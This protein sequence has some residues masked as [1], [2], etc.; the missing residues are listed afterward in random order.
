MKFPA[1]VALLASTALGMPAALE[2]RTWTGDGL[3]V[4]NVGYQGDGLY[5]ATFDKRGVAEVKFT[6]ARDLNLTARGALDDSAVELLARDQLER[7]NGVTC[8]GKSGDT[9]VMD[10]ANRQ[11]ASNADAHGVYL[12]NSWG[13]VSSQAFLVFPRSAM[14]RRRL[15]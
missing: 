7:R 5:L 4:R 15:T 12:N 6:P 2:T 11:L 9:S 10:P 3:T 14:G 13:W 8:S 1:L